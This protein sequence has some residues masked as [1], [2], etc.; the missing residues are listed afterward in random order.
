[1]SSFLKYNNI[2]ITDFA[3]VIKIEK[4]LIP[5]RE[6]NTIDI[7][8]RNGE[9]FDSSKK[10]SSEMKIKLHISGD[11]IENFEEGKRNILFAF[12]TNVSSQL[13]L[14]E[15]KFC[16]AIPKDDV[17]EE[18]INSKQCFLFVT[19][20]VFE[21]VFYSEDA[22]VFE[23]NKEVE[24]LN[25]GDYECYPIINLG[26]S[27]ESQ[28]VQV[29][30]TA[31]GKKILAGTLPILELPK[32]SEKTDIII[33]E[34][35]SISGWTTGTNSVD[36]GR[37]TDGT[38][39][40]TD[41]GDGIK[42]GIYGS[43][44]DTWKGVGARK[45]LGQNIAD[46]Y[47]EATFAHN[48][49]G[50]NGDPSVGVNATHK[51]EIKTGS[52]TKYYEAAGTTNVRSGPST[53]YKKIA[54][55]KKGDKVTPISI[56]N[57]WIKFTYNGA[58]RYVSDKYM[59]VKYKDNTTTI[60]TKNFVTLS[61]TSLRTSYNKSSKLKCTIPG[62]TTL[63]L[64]SSK[65]H[66]DPSDKNKKR[67]YY[68]LREKYNGYTGYVAE[69]QVIEASNTYYEYD[70]ELE[71]ADDKTAALEIYGYSANNE[72]IFRLGLYDDDKYY[73]FTYPLI[74][75]GSKDFLKDK[76]IA[77]KPK[78]ETSLNTSDDKLTVTTDTLLSGQY[79][80]WNDF[81]GKVGIQRQGKL[82]K[83]WVYKY[84]D[85]K[86]VKT[87]LS[88]ETTVYG[89][90]TQDLAYITLY[91]GTQD[92]SKPSGAALYKLEVKNLNPVNEEENNILKFSQGDV[93]KLDCYNNM[94]YLNDKEFSNID[95]GSQFFELEQGENIIKVRSDDE[96]I[97]TDVIF[98]ERW[99]T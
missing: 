14:E 51:E 82:W 99:L 46:F 15:N 77:P 28:F 10:K 90:P 66:L 94:V 43:G 24:C 53:K 49:S 22:K 32:E 8:E 47:V 63:R 30:N 3:R 29:E 27:K 1:M 98:N 16:Y 40:L 83:A 45:N 97:S 36:S 41:N 31:N 20:F 18:S 48:S 6:I 78:T 58:T 19:L 50:V 56:N 65:K 87:L 33:D 39:A 38:L 35:E 80:D 2:T 64:I 84:K 57:G 12:D 71:T 42:V 96:E 5:A 85:G 93:L 26:F 60:T 4:S 76:T 70:E 54:T 74:Q 86:L 7:F 88:N 55:L 25:E 73:E 67:Y 52:R 9:L 59:K 34:C 23:G 89:S 21:H 79:G 37:S 17:T 61:S 95:I 11:T 62:G 69:T 81:Y 75:V 72:K 91:I 44:N 68:K 92:T 13:Y